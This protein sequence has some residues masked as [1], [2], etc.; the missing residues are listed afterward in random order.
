MPDISTPQPDDNVQQLCAAA[1]AV[2]RPCPPHSIWLPWAVTG[3]HC[4]GSRIAM[5]TVW[6]IEKRSASRS[7]GCTEKKA[8]TA[9]WRPN[10]NTRQGGGLPCGIPSVASPV[11]HCRRQW[12]EDYTLHAATYNIMP[13]HQN[14]DPARPRLGYETDL[15]ATRTFKEQEEAS[16]SS[17]MPVTLITVGELSKI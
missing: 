2:G 6:S 8:A 1:V 12:R 7:S 3:R 17:D 15:L 10:C 16:Q 14:S 4:G 11:E 5:D 13:R 9:A